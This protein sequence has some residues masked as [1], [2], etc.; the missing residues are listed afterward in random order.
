MYS[1]SDIGT[2]NAVMCV[3]HKTVM[4]V[5]EAARSKAWVYGR[6][7]AGIVGSNA[8]T[9]EI[10]LKIGQRTLISDC[11]HRSAIRLSRGSW[12]S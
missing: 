2:S 9:L 7:L 10:Y 4:P 12:P 3:R 6:S 5:P 1:H 8:L 11:G